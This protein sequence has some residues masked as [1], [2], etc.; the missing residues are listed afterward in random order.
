[1]E[2]F[3]R[4]QLFKLTMLAL[5]LFPLVPGKVVP[6]IGAFM[7]LYFTGYLLTQKEAFRRIQRSRKRGKLAYSMSFLLFIMLAFISVIY[8]QNR[9][10]T[11]WGVFVY[12]TGFCIYLILK[13]ETN[14]P[15]YMTPLIRA[16]FISTFIV[17]FYHFGQ[18]VYDEV[19]R[20]IPFDPM[21]N[22]SFMQ[23]SP[24]LAYFMLIPLFPALALYIY[25]EKK[26]ES[27]FYLLILTMALISIFMSG[28]RI[29]VVGVFMGLAL[30]SLLY[31]IKFL[32]ALIPAGIF[33]VLIPIFTQRHDEFFIL[34]PDR[35]RFGIYFDIL[36]ENKKSLFIG[37]GFFTFDEI[38]QKFM[39]GKAS[40]LNLDL[41]NKPYNMP[42]QI[43][44]E[45]GILGVICGVLIVFFK[46]R[47][48]RIYTKSN[49]G[50]QNLKVMY[51]GVTISMIVLLF[52]GI[53][54]SYLMDPK[55][56]YSMAILMG[57]M[58][59]D[60]KWHGIHNI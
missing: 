7:G 45:L 60:G 31:S 35:S 10:Q 58:H 48:L 40:F 26:N 25:N 5:F 13:Y 38:L 51:V 11:L 56:I 49:K 52:V 55:I 29:A 46:L 21:T 15:N 59:G 1:M 37:R 19:V 42:L 18:I 50:Q 6:F 41:V 30:L 57:I 32:I 39:T 9:S 34:S 53:M 33:A 47:A 3:N 54:D 17:G 2:I 8:S 44:L 4:N 16:Y 36:K 12:A 28:S 27:R 24:S 20:N 43:I 23:N 22:F 14:R